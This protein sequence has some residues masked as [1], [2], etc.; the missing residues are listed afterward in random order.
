[1][2]TQGPWILVVD[3]SATSRVMIGRQ[4]GRLGCR[5][6]YA[7]DGRSALA[8]LEARQYQMVLLDCYLPDVN[9]Y[10]V[11]RQVRAREG[12]GAD[13]YTP[14]IGISAEADAAHVRLCLDS[15]M[16]GILGKPLPPE[17]LR[18]LL[19]LWCDH[20]AG[21]PLAGGNDRQS[22]EAT[23]L[24][25]LFHATSLQDLADMRSA[26]EAADLAALRRLAHRMKGAALILGRA[27]TVLQLER[28]EAAAREGATDLMAI[29]ALIAALEAALQA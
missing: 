26:R 28:I 3:D 18:K 5:A 12:D 10:E 4:L 6:E 13:G 20:E 8:A 11:A 2:K 21:A 17:E 24:D 23:D 1:M 15:G 29:D 7:E 22:E 16:D 14:L 19:L 9:G 27:Q 25:A